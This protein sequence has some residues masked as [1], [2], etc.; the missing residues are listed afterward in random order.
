MS[1]VHAD[2]ALQGTA[3][4]MTVS[5]G[6]V[7]RSIAIPASAKSD[8]SCAISWS[9]EAWPLSYWR[10]SAA[11]A[12]ALTP[13]PHS[14]VPMPGLVQVLVPPGLTVHPFALSSAIAAV[15]LYGYG[16]DFS[17]E[18]T[19]VELGFTGTGPYVGYAYP[20]KALLMKVFWST[21]S[22]I[23]CRKYSWLKIGPLVGFVK[24]SGK[25]VTCQPV[26]GSKLYALSSVDRSGTLLEGR[27]P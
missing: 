14:P 25:Y 23:A 18:S 22:C 4:P 20:K 21:R 6:A 13:A 9:S 1:H 15:G 19:K 16:F 12:P 26:Q 11:L 3:F 17:N 8:L 2:P 5:N 24:F 27:Y 7:V 10:L